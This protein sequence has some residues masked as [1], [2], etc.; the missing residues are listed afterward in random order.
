VTVALEGSEMKPE[1]TTAPSADQADGVLQACLGPT[2]FYRRRG[3]DVVLLVHGLTGTPAEM[4]HVAKRLL[5]QGF[6]VACPQL[7]GHC[8]SVEDLKRSK[9]EDWYGSIERTFEA[10]K[11]T[12]RR[13]FVSGLSMGALMAVKLA[14]EKGDR[15]DGLGLL[16]LTLFYDGWNMP[17]I[18]QKIFWALVLYSPLRHFMS[19]EES[20]PY[21]IKCEKARAQV[22]AILESRDSQATEKIGIFSTPAVTI[23][24]SL[25]LIKAA[26]QAFPRVLAPT[27]LVHA[28]EDDMASVKNAH[29]A[30]ARLG[31]R[32][33][34]TYFV[35]DTYHVLTLDKRKNDV[36]KRLSEFFTHCAN[37]PET[38]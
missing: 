9:W 6:S 22:Q 35:D 13:V 10:L 34:E 7:A 2:G 27:L 30:A 16:S 3:D 24:E 11:R 26:K 37:A 1:D 25:G 18:H 17:K 14:A 33:I 21:G 29:Y 38:A 12:H 19:W 23:R 20:H 4:L 8:G 5:Q 31:S 36:A 15:V 28:T 32:R